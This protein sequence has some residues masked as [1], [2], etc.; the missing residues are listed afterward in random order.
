MER[1]TDKILKLARSFPCLER[2]LC[3]WN[4][5][6]FD[7]DRFYRM[8]SGWSHGE[9]CCAMFV[10]NVWCPSDAKAKGWTFDLMEFADVA[11]SEHRMPLMQWLA[12][13]EW[14]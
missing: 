13:P 4:P 14:P 1:P 5:A 6:E 9:Q 12:N 3:G 11:D 8:M 7:P 2:K 10:L